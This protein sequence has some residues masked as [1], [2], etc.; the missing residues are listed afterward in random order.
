[1]REERRLRIVNIRVLM[2]TFGPKWDEVKEG[3]GE[4]YVMKSLMVCRPNSH[5][6][7]KPS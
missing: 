5:H 3:S 1:L 4:N 2:K 6:L 7:E